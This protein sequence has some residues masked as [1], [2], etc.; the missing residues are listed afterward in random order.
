MFK[1][2]GVAALKD[3]ERILEVGPD[4]IPSSA[5]AAVGRG[6]WEFADLEES[7]IGDAMAFSALKARQVTYRLAN[8]YQ[9]PVENGR[10]DAVVALNVAEHIP[11]PWQWIAEVSRVTRTGGVI[12]LVT[13]ISWPEHRAPVDCYRFYP[14]GMRELLTIG[15]FEPVVLE[16][17]TSEAPTRRWYPGMEYR[18]PAGPQGPKA[19]FVDAVKRLANWP[20]PSAVDLVAVGRRSA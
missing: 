20:T 14:D 1:K 9:I 7:I 16:Y 8:L 4:R 6:D 17:G 12:V 11:R 15:G 5:Q 19:R 10:F 3:A 18:W 2:W 13:P